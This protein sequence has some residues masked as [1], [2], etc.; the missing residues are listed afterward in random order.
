MQINRDYE[1]EI[2]LKDLFFH[3]LY[4]WR[5]ILAAALIGAILLGGYQALSAMKKHN[6]VNPVNVEPVTGTVSWDD[7]YTKQ[8]EELNSYKEESI[9]YKL[10]PQLVWTAKKMYLVRADLP[11][12][13]NQP[14]STDPVDSILPIYMTPLAGIA[15]DQTLNDA[16]GTTKKEY[17]SELINAEADPEMNL[18]TLSVKGSTKEAARK[19]LDCLHNQMMAISKEYDQSIAPHQLIVAGEDLAPMSD[20][21]MADNRTAFDKEISAVEGKLKE[22]REKEETQQETIQPKV[23]GRTT[24]K[25]ALIGFVLGAF[26]L[27]LVYTFHYIISGVLTDPNAYSEQFNTPIFG[28]FARSSSLHSNKGLDKLISKWELKNKNTDSRTVFNNIAALISEQVKENSVLLV[29]SLPENMLN[30][31]KEK[32]VSLLPEKCLTVQADILR[33]SDAIAD[34]GKADAVVIVEK[35]HISRMKDIGRMAEILEISK[36]KVIGSIIL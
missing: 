35:K 34:A 6:Q 21:D 9:Y 15:D 36:A 13:G 12:Q 30:K 10:D 7:V 19:G 29:S 27:M 16:F 17:I 20:K 18:I 8:L 4:R 14:R 3:I 1:P 5:S 26:L 22:A 23:F 25:W 31:V 33:N 11:A 32:L 28:D 24:L 2:N